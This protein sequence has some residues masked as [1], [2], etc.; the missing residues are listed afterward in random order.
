M[1]DQLT[2]ASK[3]LYPEPISLGYNKINLAGFLQRFSK[4]TLTKNFLKTHLALV[5]LIPF[6][7]LLVFTGLDDSVLQLDEGADTF[8]STT[9]L[10]YGYPKHS[11][12]I[13][14]AMPYGDVFD[15][16]F[17]YRTWVPY[18]LQSASLR[19]FGQNTFSAR[20]PFAILGVFSVWSLYCFTL[21]WTNR[22]TIAFMAALLLATSVPALLYFRTARYIAIPILLTP[23][24]LSSYIPI[25]DKTKWNPIPLTL[26]SIIYFH[27]MYVEFAG[28]IIGMLI[29]LYVYRG[30]VTNSNMAKVKGSA[31]ITAVF[32]LPW[33][34]IIPALMS[35]ISEF[36]TSASPLIDTTWWR[37]PKHFFAFLFQI[38][39]YIF[40]FILAPFL[41]ISS[42]KHQR[43][44]SSLLIFCSISVII[45]ASLHSIP[46]M[47][48]ISG[49]IPL[50]FILLAM[51]VFHIFE[52]SVA[53][54]S[55]LLLVLIVTNLIH[56]GPLLPIKEIANRYPEKFTVSDY[57][58]Y[59]YE[60]FTRETKLKSVFHQYWQELTHRY[61]GPLD[62]LVLFF[63]THGKKG[64]TCY[65]DSEFESLT[66]YTGMKMIPNQELSQQHPPNW[67]VLRGIDRIFDKEG[68]LSIKEQRVKEIL[69]TNAY[70]RTELDT[71]AMQANNSYDIQIHQF[72]SPSST[73][74]VSV[75]HLS[76]K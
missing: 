10:K 53:R 32:C 54:Q 62:K 8:V 5:F 75:Y 9:I 4:V 65:I 45:T 61:Q 64:D 73:D 41:F 18:Y 50:L 34:A 30:R 24:L 68:G 3:V 72:R 33:L 47:Q 40:P 38:N 26:L 2:T 42:L 23:L 37:L 1:K 48:Y 56:V 66:F 71:P 67:I 21:R 22:K 35:K 36:Y 14:Y 55:A 60:T 15:G 69:Q 19:L 25:F 31:I 27:T 29:H 57:G 12:G 16:I 74:R 51:V 63:E 49:C 39:N 58:Q 70:T 13:H 76:S 46:L 20:L 43:F 59:A 44:Q 17:V 28:V 11:D 6:T 7:I 52:K